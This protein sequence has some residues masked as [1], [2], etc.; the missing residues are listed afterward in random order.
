MSGQTTRQIHVHC[1]L[2]IIIRAMYRCI[3]FAY[4]LFLQC[5][6]TYSQKQSADERRTAGLVK[7]RF[8]TVAVD[9]FIRTVEHRR[10]KIFYLTYARP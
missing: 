5:S 4:Q 2:Y 8:Q 3:L 9:V 6:W 1:R 7:Q 10:R